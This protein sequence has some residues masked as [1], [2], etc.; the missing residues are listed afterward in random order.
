MTAFITQ[1]LFYRCLAVIFIYFFFLIEN[2]FVVEYVQTAE[3][4]AQQAC[5]Q[6]LK[7]KKWKINFL[8]PSNVTSADSI[9]L[10]K[11]KTDQECVW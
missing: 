4:R 7:E 6:L 8:L 5:D 10:G 2:F 1:F 11:K 9:I 3:L